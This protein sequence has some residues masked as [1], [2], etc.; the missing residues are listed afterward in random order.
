[1]RALSVTLL[2]SALTA[3]GASIP[4]PEAAEAI[5]LD[6][7]HRKLEGDKWL[8]YG[9][10]VE[11]DADRQVVWDVLTDA[12]GYP[13]W[14]P[15][16]V[17]IEGEIVSDGDLVL[18]STLDPDRTF[19]LHVST[20]DAPSVMVWQD[21]NDSFK[22]V[23][24]FELSERDGGTSF[25]MTETFTGSMMKMIA[26]K[27]PDMGPSFESFAAGLKAESERIQA[28]NE[29][30]PEPEPEPSTPQVQEPGG[31]DVVPAV[32]AEELRPEGAAS[33]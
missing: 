25:T 18:S 26:P 8:Q 21:G 29:P 14:N 9:M 17:G 19:P 5:A 33:E 6:G 13:S 7:T 15:T 12:A 2:L 1:M 31:Q 24:R 32:P 10:G 28:E 27:L 11:I 22:G 16:V 4:P 20:F 23:R 30:E 3:C